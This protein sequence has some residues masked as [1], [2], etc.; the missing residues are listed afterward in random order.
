[1][2]Q[3]RSRLAVLEAMVAGGRTLCAVVGCWF[4]DVLFLFPAVQCLVIKLEV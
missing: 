2:R 4:D 3:F 1:V